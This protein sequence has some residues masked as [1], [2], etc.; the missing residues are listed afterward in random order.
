MKDSE[1]LELALSRILG[2][3]A[4]DAIWARNADVDPETADRAAYEE[5]RAARGH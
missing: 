4:L 5:L 2:R 3:D 1:V